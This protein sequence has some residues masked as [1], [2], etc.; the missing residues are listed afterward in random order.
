MAQE[1][2]KWLTKDGV[3]FK[4]LEEAN[5]HEKMVGFQTDISNI[6]FEEFT[7][8]GSCFCLNESQMEDVIDFI[9]IKRRL[10]IYKAMEKFYGCDK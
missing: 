8:F 1:I 10:D 6:I 7:E 2:K 9:T 3:E 5:N 4:T